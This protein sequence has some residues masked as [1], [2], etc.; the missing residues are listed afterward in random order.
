MDVNPGRPGSPEPL[1]ATCRVP[2][3]ALPGGCLA[4]SR[5]GPGVGVHRTDCRRE[6]DARVACLNGG[7][8]GAIRLVAL[9]VEG[10]GLLDCRGGGPAGGFPRQRQGDR[11]L[12]DPV[13]GHGSDRA[14]AGVTAAGCRRPGSGPCGGQIT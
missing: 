10:N 5:R 1:F 3:L 13:S 2:G 14:G 8:G 9:K 11:A 7:S 6:L 12:L 4:G